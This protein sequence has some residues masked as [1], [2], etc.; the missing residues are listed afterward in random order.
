MN[1]MSMSDPRMNLPSESFYR[2]RSSVHN[3]NFFV[4]V[5]IERPVTRIVPTGFRPITKIKPDVISIQRFCRRQ[6]PSCCTSLPPPKTRP[7]E[8]GELTS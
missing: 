4:H 1:N 2:Q 7:S 5:V 6:L 3:L 8:N